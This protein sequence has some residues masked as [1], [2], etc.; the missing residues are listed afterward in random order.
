MNP[1]FLAITLLLC[2]VLAIAFEI[3]EAKK[4]EH[5]DKHH[6]KKSEKKCVHSFANL[7]FSSLNGT[8]EFVL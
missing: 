8:A 5:G 1:K 4:D 2:V 7:F 3:V 6:K